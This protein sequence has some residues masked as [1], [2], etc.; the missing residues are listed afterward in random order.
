[1]L[2][3]SFN[4]DSLILS[5]NA[6]KQP[7]VS[8]TKIVV[9]RQLETQSV[10]TNKSAALVT[11]L[12]ETELPICHKNIPQELKFDRLVLR[13]SP[14]IQHPRGKSI[15]LQRRHFLQLSSAAIAFKSSESLWV[16][17]DPL[18]DSPTPKFWF[19]DWVCHESVCDDELDPDNFGK[20]LRDYG[21]VI[22]LFFSSGSSRHLPGWNY[23]VSWRWVNGE[24]VDNSDWD[25]AA[26]ES[27]L[28]RSDSLTPKC[29]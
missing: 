19:G 1:M 17:S 29:H 18:S 13:G 25:D 6:G 8:G 10:Y 21:V 11:H 24:A 2:T 5:G 27:N 20:T 15:M 4:F 22:G 12:F 7:V 23:W 3:W 16:K 26:H 28:K 14:Q 9:T